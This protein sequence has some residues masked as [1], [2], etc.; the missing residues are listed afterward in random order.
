MRFVD[1]SHVIEHRMITYPGLPGPEI[2]EHMSFAESARNYA[3]GTEFSIGR[4]TMVAN[5]G[6]YL[7]TPAHRFRAGHD[8]SD[9]P[10]ERCASLPAVVVEGQ[11]DGPIGPDAFEDLAIA[12]SAVLIRTGWDAIG[13]QPGT[14]IRLTRI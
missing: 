3:S 1:L 12:N 10:L 5:T 14:E 7:D 6:T 13:A 9:L 11:G 8:L 4:L 2:S